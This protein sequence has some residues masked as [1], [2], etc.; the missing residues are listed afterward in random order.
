MAKKKVKGRKGSAA[1]KRNKDALQNYVAAQV[2]R[3]DLNREY[4]DAAHES[5]AKAMLG[6]IWGVRESN[7]FGKGKLGRKRTMKL[8]IYLQ[9]WFTEYIVL[10]GEHEEGAFEGLD[11]EAISMQL[12]EETGILIDPVTAKYTMDDKALALWMQ[13]KEE[14]K[15]E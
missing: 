14:M 8:F 13:M 4:R 15:N 7:L 12:F 10:P 3:N 11:F 2:Y 5:F 9:K 6:M 1:A